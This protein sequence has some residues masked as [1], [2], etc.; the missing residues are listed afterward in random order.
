MGKIKEP[1]ADVIIIK[2]LAKT[3]LLDW[4][5]LKE[6]EEEDCVVYSEEKAIYWL[7][8]YKEFKKIVIAI[9]NDISNYRNTITEE[10]KSDIKK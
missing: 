10:V 1:E 5:G 6:V 8:Q 4:K 2:A 7:T 9:A 3:V